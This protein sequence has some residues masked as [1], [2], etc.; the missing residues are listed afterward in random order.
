M[1]K[2][3]K[4]IK[5]LLVGSIWTYIFIYFAD[6]AMVKFWHFSLLRIDDWATI[7]TYWNSGGKIKTGKDFAFLFSIALIPAVWLWGWSLACKVNYPAL[8]LAPFEWLRNR[9]LAHYNDERIVIKNIG[10]T[11]EKVSEEELI[12]DQLKN[13]E[14]EIDENKETLKIRENI[15]EKINNLKK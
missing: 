3:F 11:E 10:L 14:K 13:L 15:A 9:S 2:L 8:L 12:K 4:L 6:M 1:R 5:I 7:S